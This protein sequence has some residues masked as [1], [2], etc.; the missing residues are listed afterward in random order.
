MAFKTD[1]Q[2]IDDIGIFSDKGEESVYMIY[3]A[4]RTQG[5]LTKLDHM[6]RNPI[7][8]K[9]IL[10]S[11]IASIKFFQDNK[12]DYPFNPENFFT[13]ENYIQN[14]DRRSQLA[15]EDNTLRR[16]M[17]QV[18]AS[19]GEFTQ[20]HTAIISLVSIINDTQDL[21]QKLSSLENSHLLTSLF[22]ELPKEVTEIAH[23]HKGAKK[24]SY[25]DCVKLDQVLRFTHQKAIVAMLNSIYLIDVYFSVAEIAI[26]RNFVFAKVISDKDNYIKM[27]GVYHPRL[28]NGIGNDIEIDENYNMMFLTGANM[29]GKSTIMKSISIALYV[30]HVGFPVAAQEM[31]FSVRSG[32]FTTI[33]LPDNINAGYSH[34]YS[35]VMRLKKVAQE[36][37]RDSNLFIIFDELFR[38]TNVKDAYDATIAVIEAF[39]KIRRCTFIVSTQII[40]AGEILAGK[41]K[42]VQFIYMPTVMENGKP[43]YTYVA[44]KGVTADR[45]GMV[46]I[47]NERILD[48]IK[49]AY[50]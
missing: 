45:H 50:N 31:E 27:R 38:G 41:C 30:A 3:N 18:I 15:L 26:K 48:I 5:G 49:T 44:K 14:T 43:R 7:N 39:S 2:T 34:F 29:A 24:I 19:D 40:E 36:V 10:D 20:M 6:F 25:E 17:S 22:N 42:N 16:R 13:T 12:M 11:R 28:K 1:N 46:I 9:D 35:E 32:M 21:L 23:L 47:R 4:C 33:N 37:S 8:D